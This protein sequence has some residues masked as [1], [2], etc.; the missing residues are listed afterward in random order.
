MTIGRGGHEGSQRN[1]VRS[2]DHP[3]ARLEMVYGRIESSESFTLGGPGILEFV[4]NKRAKR[5]HANG[6]HQSS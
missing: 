4:A 1:S 5:R 3:F 6:G 2:H